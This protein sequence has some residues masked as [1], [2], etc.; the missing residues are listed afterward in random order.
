MPAS[1][2]HSKVVPADAIETW[3]AVSW[4]KWE[5]PPGSNILCDSGD[6]GI[7]QDPGLGLEGFMWLGLYS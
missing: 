4:G 7:T 5:G 6:E 1:Y 3:I 2:C